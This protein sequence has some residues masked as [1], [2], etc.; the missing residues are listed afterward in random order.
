MLHVCGI[1]DHYTWWQGW[2]RDLE[3]AES[4]KS[5]TTNEPIEQLMPW[6]EKPD[7]IAGQ[8]KCSRRPSA[9][10]LQMR[11]HFRDGRLDCE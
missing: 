3:G 5:F 4:D 1:V 10:S 11:F 2:Y 8:G 7:A 6:L 9:V